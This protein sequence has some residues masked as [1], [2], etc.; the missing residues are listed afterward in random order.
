MAR[1]I[2]IVLHAGVIGV[3]GSP[4]EVDTGK[5]AAGG[6]AGETSP[7]G[8]STCIGAQSQFRASADFRIRLEPL[9]GGSWRGPCNHVGGET[10]G[11]RG[12]EGTVVHDIGMHD[13]YDQLA[14]CPAAEAGNLNASSCDAV[15]VGPDLRRRIDCDADGLADREEDHQ[16]LSSSESLEQAHAWWWS[17]AVIATML[18][19]LAGSDEATED[20]D[21]HGA[22]ASWG[23]GGAAAAAATR[24]CRLN[25]SDR[26]KVHGRRGPSRAR[27][28]APEKWALA[29]E[30]IGGRR[31]RRRRRHG[32][33]RAVRLGAA[34][35]S[36]GDWRPWK[37]NSD[38][39]LGT[40][41]ESTC[42]PIRGS[43]V[44]MDGSAVGHRLTMEGSGGAAS[45]RGSDSGPSAGM[46]SAAPRAAG[47]REGRS[48]TTY[49]VRRRSTGMKRGTVTVAMLVAAFI[50]CRV[51]EALHPGPQE[52]AEQLAP[53]LITADATWRHTVTYPRPHRDGFRDISTPG[54][55]EL[56][57]GHGGRDEDEEFNLEVE[58]A[59]TTG[60][61]PLQRRLAATGAHA[62]LAQETWVL[63]CHVARASSWARRHGWDSAWSPAVEGPGGGASGGVAV[64][65]RSDIGLRYPTVGSHVLEE[66]RAVAAV[67]EPPGHRPIL[68]A[69][70]YL[71]DGKAMAAENRATLAR[72]GECVESQGDEVQPLVGGDFQCHPSLVQG[73]GF[74]D[75]VGGRILAADSVRGTFRSAATASTLDYF[76]AGHRLADTIEDV[77]LEEKSGLKGHTPVKVR[78]AARPVALKALAFRRPPDI[79][80]ERIYGPVPPRPSWER[81]RK[82]AATALKVATREEDGPTIQKAIDA[83]YEQWCQCAELEIAGVTGE[84]PKK[85]GLRGQRPKLRWLSVLPEKVP[86]GTPS[87]AAEATY[88]RG[89]ATE[90]GR[91]MSQVQAEAGAGFY[92]ERPF[93][94][95][96]MPHGGTFATPVRGGYDNEASRGAG[97][98][99]ARGGRP[100][101]PVCLEECEEIA[102]DIEGELG[103]EEHNAEHKEEGDAAPRNHCE[104]VRAAA[105]R[106]KEAVHQARRAGFHT[107]DSLIGDLRELV[108]DLTRIE[109]EAERNRDS[110][111]RR[112]WKTWLEEDWGKGAKHAHAATK[113]PV[114]WRPTVAVNEDGTR[115]SAPAAILDEARRKYKQWWQATEEPI[116]YCWS[117]NC[118]PLPRLSPEEIRGASL[119]FKRGT[120]RTYDGWHVR[121]FGLLADEGLATLSVLLETVERTSR[122]PSQ[123]AVVTTPMIGKP[124]GGHRL[125][126]KLAALYRVWAKARRPHADKWEAENNRPFFA[127]AAG[128]GPIEAV[129]RQAMR[130]EAAKAAGHA[131]I[132]VL[133]DMESF[134]E[135]IDRNI[136]VDEA[137]RLGFPTC[138]VRAA[139]AAY[140]APRMIT[141]GRA[142]ARELHARR[143]LIAGCSFATT[144]VK[145]FYLRRMDAMIKEIPRSVK[146]DAYIDDLAL[147]AEGPRARAAEDVIIA[148]AVMRRI[149]TVELGCKLAPNK[150]AVVASDREL[151]RRVAKAVGRDDVCG[152]SAAN[153]GTDVTAGAKRTRL[154][155]ASKRQ[156]RFR[157][158]LGRA[159]R[160]WSVS[161]VLGRKALRIF[162]SGL[163]P[164]MSYG[165][166]VWG[167]SDSEV[168][169][170]R[171]LAG[172]AMKPQSRCRSLTLVHLVHGMPTAP[173]EVSTAVQYAR[174]VWR[175]ATQRG[176]AADR[177]MGLTDIR[178][179]WDAVQREIVPAVEAYRASIA[180]GGGRA[181]ASAARR[182]WSEVRGPVGAAIMT[183]TRIGW[184][185]T[186][187]FTMVDARGN[188]IVLTT[189]SPALVRRLLVDATID[190]A[191]RVV[192]ARWAKADPEFE[193]RRVCPDLAVKAIRGGMGGKMTAQQAACFRAAACDGIYTRHR[194]VE[195]G[196]EVED[197]CV[198]CGAEGDTNHHRIFCCPHTRAAVLQHIPA[199]LYAEGGRASPKSKFWTTGIFPH[200]AEDWPQPA[201]DFD[202]IIIG[203]EEGNPGAD[204][205]EDAVS[206]FGG[207]LFTDGSCTHSPI[208][209]LSRAGCSAV[210]ADEAG[211]RRRGI[212]MPIP[213]HL[214]QTSQSGEHVGV[215]MARRQAARPAHIR[216][217]CEN[218]V[219]AANDPA[220]K[221][222]APARTYAG[223]VLDK[224]TRLDDASRATRVSW[225]KAHRADS[226]QHSAETK[227]EI[228][229]NAEADRLA[230]EAVLL[231]PQPTHDQQVRLN[232][233]LRRAPLIAK[234]VG[235]A[236]AMFPAAEATRLTR[237]RRPASAVEARERSL[238]FWSFNQ[239]VWR[240]DCC[241][242]WVSGCDLTA[243]HRTESC[244]GHIAHRCADAWSALGHK[245]ALVKGDAPFAFC[246]RCG[247]WGNRRA[248]RLKLPCRGPTPAGAMALARIGRGQHPWRR[249]LAGGGDAPRTRIVVTKA[250]D[251]AS[252]VWGAV[253]GGGRYWRRTGGARGTNETDEDAVDARLDGGG[254]GATAGPSDI[255]RIAR[256][257]GAEDERQP[258][259]DMDLDVFE[260]GDPFGH[261]GSLSQEE[262][263]GH[264]AC[265]H[266]GVDADDH[267][268]MDVVTLEAGGPGSAS[269]E[270]ATYAIGGGDD[271]GGAGE[272]T[273][274]GAKA[275]QGRDRIEAVRRRVR[276]RLGNGLRSN[277]EDG[278]DQEE[279]V[280]SWQLS[281]GGDPPSEAGLPLPQTRGVDIVP[282][283]PGWGRR[284]G[285]SASALGQIK[286]PG[287]PA[288]RRGLL[289]ADSP[290]CR[291]GGYAD[292]LINMSVEEDLQVSCTT[293]SREGGE[294]EDV[295]AVDETENGEVGVGPRSRPRD[296]DAD[297]ADRRT[298]ARLSSDGR[299]VVDG[300][301]DQEEEVAPWQL[302]GSGEPPSLAGLPL[303]QAHGVGIFQSPY[304][305][306]RGG[307]GPAS[308]LEQIKPPS[309]PAARRG[310]LGVDSSRCRSVS[311]A[312]GLV[313]ATV[314]GNG[315]HRRAEG[316]SQ[317]ERRSNGGA[318]DAESAT[319]VESRGSGG[320]F[321]RPSLPA[322]GGS[323][324]GDEP[325]IATDPVTD[326]GAASA[327][328][329][330]EPRGLGKASCGA[331]SSCLRAANCGAST[332]LRAE[333]EY[334]QDHRPTYHRLGVLRR[335]AWQQDRVREAVRGQR[336]E[337]DRRFLW[338]VS[339][340][341][342]HYSTTVPPSD[343][344]ERGRKGLVNLQG[345][346][347]PGYTSLGVQ[348]VPHHG[349]CPSVIAFS[350]PAR[351][352]ACETNGNGDRGGD[353]H[354]RGRHPGHPSRCVG[355][356]VRDGGADRVDYESGDHGSDV[357]SHSLGGPCVKPVEEVGDG[358]PPAG[359]QRR[360][361]ALWQSRHCEGLLERGRHRVRQGHGQR[362]SPHRDHVHEEGGKE[363][364]GSDVGGTSSV[365]PCVNPERSG[366]GDRGGER[367]EEDPQRGYQ[368]DP[369]SSAPQHEDDDQRFCRRARREGD[370]GARQ[371]LLRRLCERP[372]ARRSEGGEGDQ[373]ADQQG[374][375]GGLGGARG[376]SDA[377]SRRHADGDDAG[378][379]HGPREDERGEDDGRDDRLHDDDLRHEPQEHRP[380]GE[381][382]GDG[383]PRWRRAQ[384]APGARLWCAPEADRTLATGRNDILPASSC[385]EVN[386]I[387]EKED[388]GA[389][390]A[391]A[392]REQLLQRLR[393]PKRAAPRPADDGAHRDMSSGTSCRK[394]PRRD[395]GCQDLNEEMRHVQLLTHHHHH[396]RPV[397]LPSADE[398]HCYH[399][400]QQSPTLPSL[401]YGEGRQRSGWRGNAGLSAAVSSPFHPSRHGKHV[402][403]GSSSVHSDASFP[404]LSGEGASR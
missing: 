145:V 63:Q 20:A 226:D 50:T 308:A 13:E 341:C 258:E 401:R 339:S 202:A 310:L 209:G 286:P 99:P 234:A 194:A 261:G 402:G 369:R 69:S 131:A 399:D 274:V 262:V 343:P 322:R 6:G 8:V 354:E 227:R 370:R 325:S 34:G 342:S 148:H 391:P 278:G 61:G 311:P 92:V 191:E 304:Q 58:T 54:F 11:G 59:N 301:A 150:A 255:V 18:R 183:L 46:G 102:G 331:Q 112:R 201:A 218:V 141:F 152:V 106:V 189:A 316:P 151:G 318:L 231:H 169:K 60:W 154:G 212:Y 203:D 224:Y 119:S 78:F 53:R 177:G 49:G 211:G 89:Y 155:R 26:R 378:R 158:T 364:L 386:G 109:K 376:R 15:T 254:D 9:S 198:H 334:R 48:R 181:S 336:G 375:R 359:E 51:G 176:Y 56:R 235:V 357:G 259:A 383:R 398:Q 160:L 270:H 120:A 283:P 184:S 243:R 128:A 73:S 200:P 347:P 295:H 389:P 324:V 62:L 98:G 135:T 360:Q 248:R 19:S 121:H 313:G 47:T 77:S 237:R 67:T 367:E 216:S 380:E 108:D 220:S 86:K 206:G 93:S 196:Y 186:N 174:T 143:G 193:G 319:K 282:F 90:L 294:G 43:D 297:A 340:Q 225:V 315:Q 130:Q 68:L 139:L 39:V 228:R 355:A 361:R 379:Q 134:Y 292:G 271:V 4:S 180:S 124:K 350:G 44:E 338:G 100:R 293:S 95:G 214:P 168:T 217:D 256:S 138:L 312:D 387:A 246:S 159:G 321:P 111:E 88:L 300:G 170:M 94:G 104:A 285:C 381:R 273:K 330:G 307:G 38:V 290:R 210:E 52:D 240:C 392:T 66:G 163:A 161:K 396:D 84:W 223:I 400:R 252:K 268:V 74:P 303:S 239:G 298:R 390:A 244:G 125:V 57:G 65:V 395:P 337:R 363:Y 147:T 166:E 260:E 2:W 64:F 373:R 75:Q 215:A 122:W 27:W 1:F 167:V 157:A 133:E 16:R 326:V 306:G 296:D 368:S 291:A 299:F 117:G 250:F 187:A 345:A 21:G 33:V 280:A 393:N 272:G 314:E 222:L 97:G 87:A 277:L 5:G 317:G 153:L 353:D 31:Y 352:G 205:W 377:W 230:G 179:N 116:E 229:A 22:S 320:E 403:R 253:G 72:V 105:R 233:Y 265:G 146:V 79:G 305:R 192:G 199:W 136:L 388:G 323:F 83:A 195:E 356:E 172:K 41:L 351:V 113:S 327:P 197:E 281:G 171:R 37:R 384:A 29:G 309:E 257:Q 394:R 287:E 162:T 362:K 302:P 178:A 156:A 123:T 242:T 127:A 17:F 24:R 115:S 221:A 289:G 266:E 249:R 207:D 110:E 279:D 129:Y 173:W 149:L 236:Q 332:R 385:E 333:E 263:T 12:H 275:C 241:G 247:A 264:A 142:T 91:I 365:L 288:A 208:R 358:V 284:S 101:P 219:R 3:L 40:D 328:S 76:V 82:A 164:S 232:Y 25:I 190:A 137:R 269:G 103:R 71:R 45:A 70:V 42:T 35:T 213:R 366:R 55:E 175:A 96:N 140:A 245:I 126:G 32:V 397:H 335:P 144:L 81:A 348:G 118:P 7:T 267:E 132:T 80:M 329:E 344:T 36:S 188:E 85:L 30:R 114:E 10:W 165:G 374:R 382:G 107:D 372:T 404:A 185:M 349:D 251:K 371:A 204:G 14:R 182:A 23:R 346:P 28:E 238:H 276:A